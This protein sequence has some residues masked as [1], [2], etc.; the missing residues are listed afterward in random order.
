M[1]TI[2]I[3]GSGA[4]A[5][6]SSVLLSENADQS[7]RM[8]VRNADHARDMAAR[9]ENRRL[10]PGV[11]IPPGVMISADVDEAVAGAEFLV[12]A[13]PTKYLRAT[14]EGIVSALGDDRPV[15]SVIKGLETE[16]F[17]RPSEIIA[18]VLGSRAVV[19]LCGPSHAE[20]ISR[21]LPASVVAASGDIALAK[22]V[23]EIFST[24]RFRVYTNPDI[25]GV[26]LAGALK[27]IMAIAAGICDGLGYGD[28]AKSALLTRGL[29]EM[30]RFGVAL[31]AEALTFA[32]LAGMGDLI[33]TC[34][35]PYSRN[36]M[37]GERLGRGESLSEILDSMEGVAE[38]VTT[39][40]S[41]HG[42]SEQ[43]GI[44]MP[45]TAEVYAVLF[46]EKS[47]EEATASLMLRPMRGE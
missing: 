22:R 20:E 42:L 8:W 33:T 47:P 39:A 36:R 6:A 23:Q 35:S 11:T 12:A 28:N 32:G 2:A 9:R 7:V 30:T 10:L 5:T 13:I 44:E 24:E 41:V 45:I 21:R 14:L 27:N 1:T 4:M 26:E 19:A 15:V 18:D 29:V 31:G 34:F 46:E 43:Q 38:G 40:E 16:T 3:L 37:V 17:L 25:I